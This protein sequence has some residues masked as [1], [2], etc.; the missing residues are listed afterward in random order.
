M[1]VLREALGFLLVVV[2]FLNSH[3]RAAGVGQSGESSHR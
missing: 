2:V 1:V 3:E